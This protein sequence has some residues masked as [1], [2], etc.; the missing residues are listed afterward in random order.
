MIARVFQEQTRVCDPQI[1][2][3]I[4]R[5]RT[6]GLGSLKGWFP[7]AQFGNL[8]VLLSQPRSALDILLATSTTAFPQS[9]FGRNFA[10]NIQAAI[11]DLDRARSSHA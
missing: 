7:S 8:K 1:E 10:H 3:P 6:S 2:K 11:H 5:G 4:D 9:C